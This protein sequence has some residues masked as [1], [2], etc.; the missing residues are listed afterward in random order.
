MSDESM[1]TMTMLADQEIDT[2][3]MMLDGVDTSDGPLFSVSEMA[4][5]FFARSS[6]WVRWLENEGRMS[7][8]GEEIVPI[9]TKSNA[10]KYD[11]ATVEKIA[12]A[13]T[14]NGTI[15]MPQLRQALRL[16]RIQAEIHQYLKESTYVRT[17]T[18]DPAPEHGAQV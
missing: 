14:S 10:R 7:L 16:V 9:R 13:L 5:F 11:L 12:H 4:M 15:K 6:H 1:T 18:S 17:H 2:D 8:D 3:K